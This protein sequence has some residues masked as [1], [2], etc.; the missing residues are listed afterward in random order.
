MTAAAV[1]RRSLAVKAGD[2]C[3]LEPARRGIRLVT[4]AWLIA[5][6]RQRQLPSV[7]NWCCRPLLPVVTRKT[8]LS[9]GLPGSS[10]R[11]LHVR[12][13]GTRQAMGSR[14]RRGSRSGCPRV[15]T[16]SSVNSLMSLLASAR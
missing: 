15:I 12:G 16:G 6:T 2:S 5:A 9:C 8:C 1:S 3:A 4:Q 14:V 13:G 11:T 7:A 10:P